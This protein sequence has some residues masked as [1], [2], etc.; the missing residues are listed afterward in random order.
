MN[1]RYL[2]KRIVYMG[3]STWL[4]LTLVFVITYILPGSVAEIILG[5]HATEESIA[6]IQQQ[7]GLN[8]PLHVQY[9]DWLSNF[10]VGNWGVSYVTGTSIM[11]MVVPRTIRTLQLALLTIIVVTMIAIPVGV[12]AAKMR[13]SMWDSIVTGISYVGI[14]TPSF[15]SGTV[16]LMALSTPPLSLFPSGGYVPISEGI[17]PWLRHL[18]LPVASLTI[19]M[20]AYV[21]RQ[22]RASMIE[23]LQSEYVRTARLHGV[24]EI[25]VLFKHALKNGLLPTI[26]VIA[27]N[28]GWLLGGIVIIEEIFQYPG[29][30]K[31]LMDSISSRDLPVVQIAI[32]IPTLGYIIAN[33]VA[34]LLYSYLDP[35]IK[36]GE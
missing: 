25:K 22:T 29:L 33:F 28:F 11:K 19:V 4:V 26:T 17:I 8:Q 24:E 36:L 35:R 15:V 2:G 16:L 31:L 20:M 5:T 18:I 6:E 23:A 21:M 1:L 34:D 7:L 14:S 12:F 32:I 27:L 13:N 10:L 30:G 3:F 9:F